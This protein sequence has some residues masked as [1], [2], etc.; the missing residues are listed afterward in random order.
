MSWN[1]LL[2]PVFFCGL[3]FWWIYF[4]WLPQEMSTV[5]KG[6]FSISGPRELIG[7][8]RL[9]ISG[10][11][12]LVCLI[13]PLQ[14]MCS[15]TYWRWFCCKKILLA[16]GE[17]SG[18]MDVSFGLPS[19]VALWSCATN[20]ACRVGLKLSSFWLK[21]ASCWCNLAVGPAGHSLNISPMGK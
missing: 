6:V 13:C 10:W 11:L 18:K 16:A 2:P 12:P 20:F 15:Q 21:G 5:V 4:K 3:L 14:Q 8:K 19:T 1:Q 9:L 7:V 17:D